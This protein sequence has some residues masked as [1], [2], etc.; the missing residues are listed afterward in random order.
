MRLL[1]VVAPVAGICSFGLALYSAF[2]RGS[3]IAAS[4]FFVVFL[5]CAVLVIRQ[6]KA[7][8]AAPAA[9][10]QTQRSGAHS[11][12]LQAGGDINIGGGKGGR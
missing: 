7:Q 6:R 11:T 12:N 2:E 10:N 4:A 8:A 9:P 3:Y 5:V 1:T